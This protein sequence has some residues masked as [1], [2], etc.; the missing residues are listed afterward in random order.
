MMTKTDLECG[1]QWHFGISEGGT[2]RG[3]TTKPENTAFTKAP[4]HFLVREAIQNSIDACLD[5]SKPVLVTFTFGKLRSK[6]F[7]K[8]FG[9]SRHIEAIF[10]TYQGCKNPDYRRALD[11]LKEGIGKTI[12]YLKISDYN[13]RGMTYYQDGVTEG[14]TFYGFARSGGYSQKENDTAGGSYGIGK[15]AVFMNAP[16]CITLVSSRTSDGK[17]LFEGIAP[18]CTHI[19]DGKKYR[20]TGY[21]DSNGGFPVEDCNGIP[22]RF[23]RQDIQP[24]TDI[25]LLGIDPNGIGQFK[26]EIMKAV[27]Q[28]YW[29]A[30]VQGSLEV[31]VSTD[32]FGSYDE[33]K[34]AITKA[35]IGNYMSENFGPG[36]DSQ[37]R[38]IWDYNPYPYF[39]AV[40]KAET[41]TNKFR[42]ITDQLPTLHQV[43]IYI[44]KTKSNR[45]K[46]RMAF[47]NQIGLVVFV[48]NLDSYY[49]CCGVFRCDDEE[50]Q[51]ILRGFENV[52]HDEWK[53]E[54]YRTDDPSLPRVNPKAVKKEYESA[55][56]Q[57][58]A[59]EYESSQDESLAISGALDYLY[60]SPEELLTGRDD[61][62]PAASN[63]SFG[64]P[65]G[66]TEDDGMSITTRRS[67]GDL[68]N[69][70]AQYSR[71]HEAGKILES[72]PTR[73]ERITKG[74]VCEE[75]KLLGGVSHQGCG[76][77][78][79][80]TTAG[81]QSQYQENPNGQQ[82]HYL[83]QVK[84]GFRAFARNIGGRNEHTLIINSP[85]DIVYGIIQVFSCL[86]QGDAI[87]DS[88]V[89]S[90]QGKI[91]GNAIIGIPLYKGRNRLD[92]IAFKDNLKHT[93]TIKAYEIK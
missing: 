25:Y 27:L 70:P 84:V 32:D 30:V 62:D 64:I 77:N 80:E 42:H 47:V 43:S 40:C 16:A 67:G 20:E 26:K 1:C 90:A 83:S 45:S 59:H 79:K 3:P 37:N 74:S 82:G 8:L 65:T 22:R 69:A 68:A 36:I 66:S 54:N 17:V 5:A 24:G 28:N 63:S 50:G 23:I 58:L 53:A 10:T 33:S 76:A 91:K 14:G 48:D 61:D 93:I 75:D 15:A 81:S 44:N 7:P 2:D 49:G 19:L 38:R 39:E 4:R 18:L 57:V 72:R 51:R 12:H 52:A 92:G 9:L 86:E 56:M 6:S 78:P 41:G 21:Y 29:M 87:S 13:T 11:L 73:A 34:Y 46:D 88:I 71:N 55:I 89:A 85:R 60:F 35:T 31:N